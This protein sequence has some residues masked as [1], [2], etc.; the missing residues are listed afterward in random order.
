MYITKYVI[1]QHNALRAGKHYDLRIQYK[2]KNALASFALPKA[3]FPEKGERL[4]VVRTPDHAIDE[5]L[6]PHDPIPEGEYG[7]GTFDLIQIGDM[8]VYGWSSRLITFS[9]DGKIS[10]KFTIIKT[11][12]GKKRGEIEKGD[13]WLLIRNKETLAENVILNMLR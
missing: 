2:N 11:N 12:Y 9:I 3:K 5:W 8:F 7:A 13:Y 1:H 4:L 10:G 6:G